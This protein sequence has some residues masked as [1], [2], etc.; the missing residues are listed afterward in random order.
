MN[1]KK[2]GL[3]KR[4]DEN[5]SL[6]D[7]CYYEH[8]EKLNLQTL[9]NAFCARMKEDLIVTLNNPDRLERCASLQNISLLDYIE[10]VDTVYTWCPIQKKI[11]MIT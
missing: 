1:G 10:R 9:A 7:A 5:G 6:Q 8:G 2:E 11:L 3:Y 4:W